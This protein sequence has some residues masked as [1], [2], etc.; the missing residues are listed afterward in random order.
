MEI[1]CRSRIMAVICCLA[2][3]ALAGPLSATGYAHGPCAAQKHCGG[4]DC[5]GGDCECG[6]DCG[7]G[8][9]SDCDCGGKS[10]PCEEEGEAMG[11]GGHHGPGPHRMMEGM[12]GMKEHLDKVRQAVS[13]LR[14]NEREM[15]GLTDAAAF[16]AAAVKQ[17]K[18]IDDVLEAHLK[19]MESMTGRM[20]GKMPPG[21]GGGM[22]M[23][24][25]GGGPGK[26]G[27]K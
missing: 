23:A 21:H 3:L 17:F 7:C 25:E 9:N 14:R 5:G 15:A 11:P 19:H 10:C 18:M 24:P 20:Q 2:V 6:G 1:V 27:P 26:P 22:K 8:D 12:A 4:H 16:R 13:E